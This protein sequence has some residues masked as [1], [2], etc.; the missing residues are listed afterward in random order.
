[1]NRLRDASEEGGSQVSPPVVQ[2][3]TTLRH[4]GLEILVQLL[5]RR[6]GWTSRLRWRCLLQHEIRIPPLEATDSRLEGSRTRET[7]CRLLLER[8]DC[9]LLGKRVASLLHSSDRDT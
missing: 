6:F 3:T 1:M 5:L 4:V 2:V 8:H 7:V 9:L